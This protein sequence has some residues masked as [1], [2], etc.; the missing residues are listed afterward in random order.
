M[1]REQD[2]TALNQAWDDQRKLEATRQKNIEDLAK[3][4]RAVSTAMA[5][6]GVS[7]GS[8]TPEMLVEEVGRLH[9]VVWERE[10]AMARHVVHR[11]CTSR[12]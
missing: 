11:V 3:L 7:L 5:G 6:L 10:L 12:C 1:A 9:D 4:E 2:A 8:V